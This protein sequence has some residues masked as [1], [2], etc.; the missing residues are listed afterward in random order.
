MRNSLGYTSQGAFVA[1]GN[2]FQTA[3]GQ[4]RDA[5]VK[6]EDGKAS[7]VFRDIVDSQLK[8]GT[9]YIHIERRSRCDC[10]CVGHKPCAD[11]HRY[12]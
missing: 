10:P 1:T 5:L 11:G 8:A 7:K 3:L 4:T 2:D 12:Q 6:A 9:G